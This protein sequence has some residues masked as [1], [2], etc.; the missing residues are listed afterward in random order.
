MPDSHDL[1]GPEAVPAQPVT[2]THVGARRYRG[3]EA[4]ARGA[5]ARAGEETALLFDTDDPGGQVSVTGVSRTIE[6]RTGPA[7]PRPTSG[8]NVERGTLLQIGRTPT[9][10]RPILLAVAG[11]VLVAVALVKPWAWLSPATAA[12]AG[13]SASPSPVEVAL[14][15]PGTSPGPSP[16]PASGGDAGSAA[17]RGGWPPPSG[18][19]PR[20]LPGFAPGNDGDGDGGSVPSLEGPA[21]SLSPISLER[22]PRTAAAISATPDPV[23]CLLTSGWRI[24]VDQANPAAMPGPGTS[25]TWVPTSLAQAAGPTDRSILFAHVDATA[26]SAVGVCAG[27]GAVG[28]RSVTIWRL[29]S[30]N[31]SLGG[32]TRA[33]VVTQMRVPAEADGVL[34]APVSGAGTCTPPVSEY[35]CPPLDAWPAGRYVLQV[36]DVQTGLTEGWLGLELARPTIP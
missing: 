14:A 31:P 5:S 16:I 35:G 4:R 8:G 7:T 27:P 24:I 23:T 6:R 32:A 34:F 30:S 12:G 20:F 26:A 33:V 9:S 19:D 18:S 2:V 22:G 17:S 15:P 11:A 13:P 29:V 1:G 28:G 21:A 36:T 10:R 3:L 25:R